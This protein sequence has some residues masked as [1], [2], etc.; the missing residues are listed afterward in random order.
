MESQKNDNKTSTESIRFGKFYQQ[1]K[2]KLF[3]SSVFNQFNQWMNEM[4]EC[5]S[6]DLDWGNQSKNRLKYH[7]LPHSSAIEIEIEF[8]TWKKQK[9]V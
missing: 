9:P 7:L 2:K 1:N 5:V 8:S 6:E 3:S 4:K